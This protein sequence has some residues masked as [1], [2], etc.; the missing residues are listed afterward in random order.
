MGKAKEAPNRKTLIDM[1]GKRQTMALVATMA[2]SMMAQGCTLS[3][4][5]VKE[6]TVAKGGKTVVEVRKLPSGIEAVKVDASIDVHYTQGKPSIKVTAPASLMSHVT[7]T[8]SG[9]TLTVG[10]KSDG[11]KGIDTRDID[12]F[13]STPSLREVTVNGSGDFEADDK[14]KAEAITLTVKG[15]GDAE[16]KHLT[17]DELTASVHGSGDIDVDK[18]KARSAAWAV[19]G[20]GDIEATMDGVQSFSVHINGSGDTKLH[21]NDCGNGQ[22][23]INGSGDVMLSGQ[24]RSL[25]Q[26]VNGSGDIHTASLNVGK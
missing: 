15:S 8:T 3:V 6:K 21:C 7:T 16:F 24:V 12:V 14:V 9:S 4:S 1:K 20:S 10:C 2:V 25:S 26:S 5:D 18:L 17:C 23:S 13:V 11:W 19:N 22:V